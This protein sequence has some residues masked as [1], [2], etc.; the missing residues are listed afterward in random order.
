LDE[1]YRIK[2]DVKCVILFLLNS[3]T[4][5]TSQTST[6]NHIIYKT[7]KST[8]FDYNIKITIAV[9]TQI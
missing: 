5:Y 9:V 8:T 2:V 1:Y 6:I 4:K 7:Y 3:K